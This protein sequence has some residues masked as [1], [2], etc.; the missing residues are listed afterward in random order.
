M[1]DFDITMMT[2]RPIDLYVGRLSKEKRILMGRHYLKV[3]LDTQ[4][5][6]KEI[7]G[8]SNEIVIDPVKYIG[9]DWFSTFIHTGDRERMF[10]EFKSTLK[11]NNSGWKLHRNRIIWPDG[12]QRYLYFLNTVKYIGDEKVVDSFGIERFE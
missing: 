12:S 6:I 2:S 10:E 1:L 3:I 8:R 11:A 4:G 5:T 9:M 7:D